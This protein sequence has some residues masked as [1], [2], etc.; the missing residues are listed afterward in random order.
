MSEV[1]AIAIRGTRVPIPPGASPAAVKQA[2][3]RIESRLE[4]IQAASAKLNTYTFALQLNLELM[5]EILAQE[6][7]HKSEIHDL[8]RQLTKLNDALEQALSEH[9]P[10]ERS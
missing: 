6:A 4:T 1:S 10:G 5:L 3:Q 8:L 2:A 9:E 7:T